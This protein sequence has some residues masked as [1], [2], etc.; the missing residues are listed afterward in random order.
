MV[1]WNLHTALTNNTPPVRL[2]W[3]LLKEKGAKVTEHKLNTR[4]GPSDGGMKGNRVKRNKWR[5]RKK[6]KRYR[7]YGTA[8][9]HE[10]LLLPGRSNRWG[11]IEER[12]DRPLQ[13]I[14]TH[15]LGSCV[16]STLSNQNQDNY[17]GGESTC[18]YADRERERERE[19][20]QEEEEV[21][22]FKICFNFYY[23][24][25]Y[26]CCVLQKILI[27][28]EIIHT[29]SMNVG[30]TKAMLLKVWGR[31]TTALLLSLLELWNFNLI[32]FDSL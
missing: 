21:R 14:C 3:F 10:V 4:Y 29:K 25:P 1:G 13:S 6:K 22:E 8:I 30:V 9:H 23:N 2:W 15:N 5:S 19:R 26:T 28:L 27:G 20:P 18:R 16:R 17:K 32:W 11:E 12:A 24:T 31:E 7:Q